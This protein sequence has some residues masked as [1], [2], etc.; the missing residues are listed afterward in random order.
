MIFKTSTT[1]EHGKWMQPSTNNNTV[2]LERPS[3]HV[4]K[5][6]TEPD[7]YDHTPSVPLIHC[8]DSKTRFQFIRDITT[9]S[10]SEEQSYSSRRVTATVR[11][12]ATAAVVIVV[13]A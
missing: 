2:T 13:V 8:D 3:L 7:T 6:I 12:T 10:I 11:K 4:S 5:A 1:N 9:I